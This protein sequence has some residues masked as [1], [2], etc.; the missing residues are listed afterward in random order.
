MNGDARAPRMPAAWDRASP[1]ERVALVVAAVVVVGAVLWAFAWQPLARDVA[2]L[3]EQAPRDAAT[4][5]TARFLANDIA[6]LERAAP[7]ARGDLR[8]DVERTLA[9][10]G[11]R[12]PAITLE[13]TGDR[14]RVTAPVAAFA[15]LATAVDAV[16][17]DAGAFIVEATVT[18][19]VEPGTVRA[20]LVFAR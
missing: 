19:R 17:K 9:A 8:S 3:R 1:R 13:V 20:E 5:A 18:P 7:P 10:N 4:L 15:T 6:G 11:F 12:A 14:L 16:R 2:T